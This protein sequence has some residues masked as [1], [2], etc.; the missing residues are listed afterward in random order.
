MPRHD[1]NRTIQEYNYNSDLQ[2]PQDY[3]PNLEFEANN[4]SAH[5]LHAAGSIS[6]LYNI[7]GIKITKMT[8]R[9]CS[10]DMLRYLHVQA[11]LLMRIFSQL[12]LT[13]GKHPFLSKQET[14]CF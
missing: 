14:P 7:V 12:M 9:W 8:G 11:E 6:L 2:D 1:T 10:N 5:S 13:H 3:G 4:V